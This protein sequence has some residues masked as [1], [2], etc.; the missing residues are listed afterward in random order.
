MRARVVS[1][2]FAPDREA[3]IK[4]QARLIDLTLNWRPGIKRKRGASAKSQNFD[5]K[6]T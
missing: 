4:R 6:K 1:S 3:Q 2:S 5:T